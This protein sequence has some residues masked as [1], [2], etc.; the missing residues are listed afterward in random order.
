[1]AKGDKRT[2]APNKTDLQGEFV[3]LRSQ[4][5]TYKEISEKLGIPI[6]TIGNWNKSLLASIAHHRAI[7]LDTLYKT[8]LMSH[9]SRIEL[10]GTQL[11]AVLAELSTRD[12]KDVSTG[13]LFSLMFEL[14]TRLDSLYIEP[15]PIAEDDIKMIDGSVSHEQP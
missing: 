7:E 2:P 10:L 11:N 9:Q 1:M 4:G 15:R 3:I 12:L 13:T 6:A 14:Q 5:Y 8:Y